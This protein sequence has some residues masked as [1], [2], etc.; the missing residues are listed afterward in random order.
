VKR[1]R[2]RRRKRAGLMTTTAAV[3][4]GLMVT[5]G[6]AGGDS[7]S[8]EGSSGEVTRKNKAVIS[9]A[10]AGWRDGTGNV[11]E[12]LEPDAKW[13][14][15]G[16]ATVSKT[17][18]SRQEFMDAVI[19]PFNARMS[20]RLV[21]NVRGIYGD[22]DMVIALFDAQAMALDGKPYRNTYT[23]YMRMREGRIT[24]VVAFFDTIEF[25]DLWR[26]VEPSSLK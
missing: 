2:F 25:M 17:Y 1:W 6:Y 10:F 22:G 9:A 7:S 18:G 20:R 24:E 26:R 15:V 21:P 14:I 16:N 13:T 8:T 5:G 4:L 12:L 3:A 19:T 23:W 11:F